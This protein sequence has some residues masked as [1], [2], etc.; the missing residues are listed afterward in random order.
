MTKSTLAQNLNEVLG[1]NATDYDIYGAVTENMDNPGDLP[2]YRAGYDFTPYGTELTQDADMKEDYLNS[3]VK[4]IGVIFQRSAQAQNSLREFIRGQM[5]QAGMIQSMIYDTVSPKRYQPIYRGPEDSPFR[6]ALQEPYSKIHKNIVNSRS[7]VTIIDT[8]DNEYFQ[9]L[10]Q[11]HEYIWNKLNSMISGA[12]NDLYYNTKL[13][14]TTPISDTVDILNRKAK[15]GQIIKIDTTDGTSNDIAY[16]IKLYSEMFQY[17]SR[18]NNAAGLNQATRVDKIDVIID[19]KTSVN[20]DMKF[21]GTLFNAENGKPDARVNRI[22]I[23]KFP[24]VWK[25]PK[26]HVVTKEDFDGPEG[27]GK[28]PYIDIDN[29]H[30]GDVIKAGT[31]A[32]AHAPEAK[33]YLDG[34]KV[35]VVIMDHDAVQVYDMLPFRIASQFDA[36]N[37]SINVYLHKKHLF[38]FIQGLNAV[39]IVDKGVIPEDTDPNNSGSNGSNGSTG[40]EGS[41]SSNGSNSSTGNNSSTASTRS[42][43]KSSGSA[44]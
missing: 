43:N 4:K 9:S 11:F 3:L 30:I 33:Q 32:K 10:T 40:S 36:R 31:L 29:Y 17:F 14:F 22:K 34:D 15:D 13:T 7:E 2:T 18:D 21:F 19:T 23:D 6:Q 8:N 5:P 28:H 20:L 37:R 38:A 39:A 41:N 27:D 25:Y 35:H 24:D 42:T 16:K 12:V 44:T 26:D 1:T